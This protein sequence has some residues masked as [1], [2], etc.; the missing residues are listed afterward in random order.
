M[1][2]LARLRSLWQPRERTDDSVWDGDTSAWL[3]SLFAHLGVL[4]ALT[5]VTIMVPRREEFLVVI[6]GMEQEDPLASAESFSVADAPPDEIGATSAGDADALQVVAPTLSK[7]VVMPVELPLE[8]PAPVMER[9]NVQDEIR[10]ATGPKFQ[11]NLT[12]KGIAGVGVSGAVGAIDR[13]TEEILRALE[14]RETLVVWFFDQSASLESDRAEIVERF[15][16]VYEELGV[17]EAGQNPAFEQHES[18]PLLTAAVSFGET[19]SFLTPKPTDD[20]AA[21]KSAISGIKTDT[22]G[23]ER[24]FSAVREAAERYRTYRTQPPRRNVLFIIF[25]DEIGD[26]DS[27]LDETLTIC[28]RHAISVFCVGVP[29]PFG[30]REVL[31]RY[32]DPD[33]KFDQSPQWLPVRQGPESFQA[34]LVKIGSAESDEPMDSGFGPYSLTRLCYETGGIYF[35]VQPERK[36]RRG[37]HET[38]ASAAV[39]RGKF[40]PQIMLNYR[41]DYVAVKEYERLLADNKARAALVQASQYSWL[42]PME[43]PRLMFPKASEAELA[44]TLTLAQRDAAVLGPK[45]EQLY[46]TLKAGEKD[47]DRLTTPRWQAGYDLSMGLVLALMV[48]TESYNAMLAKA[49]A[50]MK[51]K[52]ADSDTW[53]LAPADE[54]SVGSA[55][56]KAA[57]EARTY[58]ERVVREHPQTPWAVLAQAEL[59]QPLGW[60]WKEA[61]TGVLARREAAN[62]QPR[63]PRDDK[64]KMLPRPVKRPPPKL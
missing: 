2:A 7:D 39:L 8:A 37:R 64:A 49:K 14:E 58:L 23:L 9:I 48:R 42:T 29:A 57:G 43:Q 20:V 6:S 22:S 46:Q 54:I 59:K 52:T 26:D 61:N 19:I 10:A 16:R 3:L 53:L 31:V 11:E 13:I 21:L 1:N 27:E 33:P 28:R 5:V 41:P 47:R 25:T 4:V 50:G 17:I 51:F 60:T 62:N 40:D 55:L 38:G 35:A 36:G 63:P 45:I 30:R 18:K 24:T 12:V 44:N 34:E 56:E 15:D 32:V